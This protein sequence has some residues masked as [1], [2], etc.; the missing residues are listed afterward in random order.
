MTGL[1]DNTVHNAA[2]SGCRLAKELGSWGLLYRDPG[3]LSLKQLAPGLSPPTQ[4]PAPLPWL[5]VPSYRLCWDLVDFQ[6]LLS[7]RPLRT[8]LGMDMWSDSIPGRGSWERKDAI[9]GV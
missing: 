2:H 8:D 6:R 3:L 4:G 7:L 1:N 5:P 9:M